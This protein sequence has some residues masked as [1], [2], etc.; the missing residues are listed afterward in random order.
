MFKLNFWQSFLVFNY[1]IIL[2]IWFL[3]CDIKCLVSW[4][5]TKNSEIMCLCLMQFFGEQ[6]R[7]YINLTQGASTHVWS[8]IERVYTPTLIATL[9]VDRKY[10]FIISLKWDTRWC[11]LFFWIRNIATNVESVFTCTWLLFTIVVMWQHFSQ[12]QPNMKCLCKFSKD[13]PISATNANL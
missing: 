7:R 10:A 6:A 4:K 11:L 8:H 9:K 3:L 12:E 2:N 5:K 1:G 13:F